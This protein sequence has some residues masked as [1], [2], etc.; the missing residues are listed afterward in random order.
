MKKLRLHLYI[1]LALF[2]IL[3]FLGSLFDLQL[4]ESIFSSKNGFGLWI[5]ALGTIPGY[6]MFAFM[7]GGLLFCALKQNEKKWFK[8]CLIAL[9]V[10]AY[11]AG[12][13]F[14]GREWFSVNGFN[15]SNLYWLGFVINAPIMCGLYFL[16]Y[17]L[18]KKV[19]EPRLWILYFIL[20]LGMAVALVPGVTLLKIIFHRPRYRSIVLYDDMFYHNWWE[21]CHNYK[22]LLGKY[23]A[24]TKEEFK[25]FPSGHA[26][27]TFVFLFVVCYLPFFGKKVG[28][29][30][31]PLMYAGVVWTLLVCFSR[32]LLGAHFLSDVSMGALLSIICLI[33]CNEIIIH[34]KACIEMLEKAQEK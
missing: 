14:S 8:I 11:I 28:R 31:I 6:G 34:N 26:G 24:L 13:Y 4:S 30:Q 12:L 18:N 27:G 1:F 16:G 21:P 33:V 32:I 5:S 22:T 7:G 23:A 20:I 15:I 2:L 9:S 17:F 29:Y 19:D 3:L 25:S 10:L